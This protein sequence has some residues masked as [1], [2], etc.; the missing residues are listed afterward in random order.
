MKDGELDIII[1]Y[2]VNYNFSKNITVNFKLCQIGELLDTITE[3][4]GFE[5]IIKFKC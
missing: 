2:K 1:P 3:N 5:D 4:N